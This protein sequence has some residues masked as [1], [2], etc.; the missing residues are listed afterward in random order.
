MEPP[1]GINER[2]MLRIS[3]NTL[4]KSQDLP[5]IAIA[6]SLNILGKVSLSVTCVKKPKTIRTDFIQFSNGRNSINS[7]NIKCYKLTIELTTFL[8]SPKYEPSFFHGSY[9][10]YHSCAR[11]QSEIAPPKKATMSLSLGKCGSKRYYSL[12]IDTQHSTCL[13]DTIMMLHQ[14]GSPFMAVCSMITDHFLK[15]SNS[16]P[17]KYLFIALNAINQLIKVRLK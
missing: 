14:S 12:S 3:S 4:Q 10:D 8:Y 13:E 1:A 15:T 11:S 16:T 6:R 9:I 7:H 5:L 2:S 17:L